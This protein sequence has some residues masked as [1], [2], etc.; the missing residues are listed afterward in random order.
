MQLPFSQQTQRWLIQTHVKNG[1]ASVIHNGA[2]HMLNVNGE[3]GLTIMK[4]L[5]SASGQKLT[6]IELKINF[7]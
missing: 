1:K 3:T 7:P 2:S 6:L 5:K 4:Q